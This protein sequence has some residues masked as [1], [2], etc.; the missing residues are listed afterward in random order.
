MAKHA[1]IEWDLPEGNRSPDGSMTYAWNSV[2]A[3]L[4]MDI[5][6]EL[7]KLNTLLYCS[8]FTGIPSTLLEIKR[9]TTKQKKL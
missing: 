7:R 4:L 6:A 3:A 8:K 2:H 1:N 9:N 5:R